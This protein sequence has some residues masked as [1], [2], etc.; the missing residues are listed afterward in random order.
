DTFVLRFKKPA[1]AP[2]SDKRPAM[3]AMEGYFGNTRRGNYTAGGAVTGQ[4]ER[5]V[6]YQKDGTYQEFGAKGS[7][8][9]PFQSGTWFVSA[10]AGV[11]M[12]HKFPPDQRDLTTCS[13]MS[14]L[15]VKPG[16]D[17]STPDGRKTLI[18]PGYSYF[19]SQNNDSSGQ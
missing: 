19:D 10:D 4:R 3:A 11:C 6:F 16:G 14:P 5:R 8:N 18:V 13:D 17:Y 15:N 12:H 9:N 1:D 7:G 2:N